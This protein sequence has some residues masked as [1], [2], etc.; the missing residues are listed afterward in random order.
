MKLRSC[1]PNS[2]QKSGSKRGFTLIELLVVIAIIAILAGMLLPALAKA[3][4]KAQGI[5]CMN[6]TKQLMLAWRMYVEDNNDELPYAYVATGAPMSPFAWVQGTLDFSADPENYDPAVNIHK[7]PLWKYC[8]NNEEIWRCPSDQSTVRDRTGKTRPRVRSM[9]M[10]NWVGGDGTNPSN[11]SGLWGSEWRVYRKMTDMVDPGPAN[12]WVLIDERED[13][14][15]DGFFVVDMNGYPNPAATRMPD[16]P[17][18]YHNNAAG[19]AFADGHSEIHKW[20]HPFT[21]RP[22]KKGTEIPGGATPNNQDVTWLQD[23]ATRRR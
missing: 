14:I 19:V 23:R 16:L 5:K 13:S 2:I 11:P 10:N 6:N 15:N 1:C 20:K 21:L 22:I 18:I 17:A 12:T 4:A 7:S 9:S 8:G 3:K